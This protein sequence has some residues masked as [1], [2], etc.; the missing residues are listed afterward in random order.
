[1]GHEM[2]IVEVLRSNE[3]KYWWQNHNFIENEI[4]NY[5]GSLLDLNISPDDKMLSFVSGD[6]TL[7]T[8]DIERGIRRKIVSCWMAPDYS[9]SP[10]GQWFVYAAPNENY[11]RKYF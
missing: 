3:D 5:R 11:N 7:W 2:S 10:D 6:G 8:Y 1:M 9:W 4:F